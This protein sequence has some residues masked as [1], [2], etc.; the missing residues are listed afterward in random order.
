M[1]LL[2]EKTKYTFTLR[3]QSKTKS[4]HT[5]PIHPLKTPH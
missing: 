2:A 5:D 1:P 3:Q 4:Q